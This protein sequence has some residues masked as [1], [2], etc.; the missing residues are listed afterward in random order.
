[1]YTIETN[2]ITG[3]TIIREWTQEEINANNARSILI[4]WNQLREKRNKLLYESDIYVH[5]DRWSSYDDAKKIEW[6]TYRQA[7][8]DLPANTS[9]PF[10]PVWPVKPS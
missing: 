5:S 10:N 4:C 3:E 6:T 2:S 7:L 9:D 8:R 1:M